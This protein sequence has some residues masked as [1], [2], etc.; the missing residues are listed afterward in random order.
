RD[1]TPASAGTVSIPAARSISAERKRTTRASMVSSS[2]SPTS[3]ATPLGLQV[4]QNDS[5]KPCSSHQSPLDLNTA[6][7]AG[8]HC[9][10]TAWGSPCSQ[11]PSSRAPDVAGAGFGLE[12]GAGALVPLP[13]SSQA[14]APSTES[15]QRQRL[16][17]TFTGLPF[18][19]VAVA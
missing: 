16:H 11:R 14:L 2:V 12:A 13:A 18:R 10:Q 19:S 7:N 9:V 8:L 5:G 4:G 6:A 17:H 15:A 3:G 1:A